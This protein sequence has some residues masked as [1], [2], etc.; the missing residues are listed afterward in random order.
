MLSPFGRLLLLGASAVALLAG[1][2]A[3]ATV[4]G[5]VLI[6]LLMTIAWSPGSLWLRKRGWPPTLA[7]LT[8]IFIGVVVIALLGLLIWSSALQLEAKLPEYQDRLTEL[9]DSATAMLARLPFDASG[10]SSA[11]ALQP[12]A[13]VQR[14][15]QVVGGIT[16][17]AGTF[18]LLI[19]IM[20]FMMIESVRYPQKL[21]AAIDAKRDADR[22]GATAKQLDRFVTSMRSYIVLNTVFG[23]LAAVANTLLLWAIGV[24]LALLWGVLSF[25]LSFLP[26]IGF[27]IALAPPALLALLQL[28][29]PRALMVVVGF[30][31]INTVVDNVIKPRFVGESLDLSPAVV[32][33]SLVFWGWLLGP[34]GALLAVPLSIAVKFLLESYGEVRWLGYLLSD[35][36]GAP[37]HESGSKA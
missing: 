2:R 33:L 5:P 35:R 11:E 8:G 28:G 36:D 20:A 23:L 30:I 24:D 27:V 16:S 26:N 10:L 17:T 19:L 18:S 14:A 32:V 22:E 37:N 25:L 15:L 3:A 31:I 12:G 4:I 34:V 21:F 9:R 1:M 6:A 7:A 13:L 29:V